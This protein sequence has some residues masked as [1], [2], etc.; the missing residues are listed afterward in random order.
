MHPYAQQELC[1]VTVDSTDHNMIIWERPAIDAGIVAYKLY[2]ETNANNV[3]E[4]MA[5]LPYSAMTTY[6]DTASNPSQQSDRY[7]ISVIDTCGN[8][9]DLS[10]AH[11]TMHL[12]VSTG[13]GVYNLIWENYEG[14]TFPSYTIY[15]GTSPNF[16]LPIGAIQ[17]SLTSYTDYQPI[18]TFYYRIAVMKNDSCWATGNAK[19]MTGPFS[20]SLSNIEDNGILPVGINNINEERNI[21]VFPNPFTESTMVYFKNNLNSNYVLTITDIT[22]KIIKQINNITGNKIEIARGSMNSGFYMIELKG[23]KTYHQTIVIE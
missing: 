17:S 2:K 15:R 11:K 22:G 19:E 9:S 3:Y 21:S 7:K 18:G 16:M 10:T 6:V 14:F 8:E 13:V 20:Q 23:D 1:L 5:S 12:T 4:L